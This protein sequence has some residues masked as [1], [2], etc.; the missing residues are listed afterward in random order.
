MFGFGK[1]K[2][3][4]INGELIIRA[5][6]ARRACRQEDKQALLNDIAAYEKSPSQN[7]EDD[8]INTVVRI[9]AWIAL[10]T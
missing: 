9:E 7:T 8:L 2:E 4:K 1:K 10:R 6:N 3:H 5:H